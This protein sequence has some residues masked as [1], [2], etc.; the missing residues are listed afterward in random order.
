MKKVIAIGVL[1]LMLAKVNAQTTNDRMTVATSTNKTTTPVVGV[2]QIDTKG[3]T[4]SRYT[5]ATP[6]MKNGAVPS[7]TKTASV[8]TGVSVDRYT[9]VAAP[10]TTGEP[11]K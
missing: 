1:F 9:P 8:S 10:V 2:Q 6:V 4:Q 3:A 7:K 11:K 5:P